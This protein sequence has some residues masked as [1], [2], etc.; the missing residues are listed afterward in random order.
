VNNAYAESINFPIFSVNLGIRPGSYFEL[1]KGY[2]V[3]HYNHKAKQFSKTKYG[4][5]NNGI[6][7]KGRNSDSDAVYSFNTNNSPIIY[8]NPVIQTVVS[9][10]SGQMT[11]INSI[12]PVSV[13]A[14][15]I[16]NSGT[17]MTGSVS[18]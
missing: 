3:N 2:P 4:T 1:V 5:I 13:A 12:N 17:V 7:I 6:F 18:S 9:P 8:V 11:P 14:A 16:I 15:S 10:T